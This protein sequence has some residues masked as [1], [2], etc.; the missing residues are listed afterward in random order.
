MDL[1][2]LIENESKRFKEKKGFLSNWFDQRF[3]KCTTNITKML[4]IKDIKKIFAKNKEKPHETTQL[5]R[6]ITSEEERDGSSNKWYRFKS[7]NVSLE[8]G[9]SQQNQCDS[10]GYEILEAKSMG[11]AKNLEDASTIVMTESQSSC[12]SSVITVIEMIENNSEDNVENWKEPESVSIL[13]EQ[14]INNREMMYIPISNIEIEVPIEAKYFYLDPAQIC[15]T[16]ENYEE[17]ITNILKV[18]EQEIKTNFRQDT[19][20]SDGTI[21]SPNI[22]EINQQILEISNETEEKCLLDQPDYS[23]PVLSSENTDSSDWKIKSFTEVR[24]VQSSEENDQLEF[25]E[26]SNY[27]DSTIDLQSAEKS[28]SKSLQFPVLSQNQE[29]QSREPIAILENSQSSSEEWLSAQSKS[30]SES[31]CE[32]K[33]YPTFGRTERANSDTCQVTLHKNNS[34]TLGF[35]MYENLGEVRITE[36]LTM[37]HPKDEATRNLSH[38]NKEEEEESSKRVNEAKYVES[39]TEIFYDA[40]SPD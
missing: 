6:N 37:I 34:F 15:S 8:S 28:L 1:C 5:W 22:M 38:E 31:N 3:K 2:H 26:E 30:S 7:V 4:S 13:E 14:E 39:T 9:D 16:K 20:K 25:S 10:S 27:E 23:F 18:G 35:D 17:L 29:I 33:E 32:S 40:T 11:D 36:R 19:A 24:C 21:R 12:S